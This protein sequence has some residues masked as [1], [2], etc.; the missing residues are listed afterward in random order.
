MLPTLVSLVLR[1]LTL[2]WMFGKLSR[3][4]SV[5]REGNAVLCAWPWGRICVSLFV[6]T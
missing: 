4:Q 3:P 5:S 6:L 2:S 1:E